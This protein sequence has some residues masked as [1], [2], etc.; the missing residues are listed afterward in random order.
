[1]PCPACPHGNTPPAPPPGHTPP[2]LAAQAFTAMTA[3]ARFALG[4]F[5]VLSNEAQAARAQVCEGC[6]Y[7]RGD[8][9]TACGCT[10]SIKTWMPAEH[11]PHDLWPK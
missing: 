11:C 6:P 2:S 3:A 9:C 1:V 8:Q 4:G 7:R 5:R 10:L